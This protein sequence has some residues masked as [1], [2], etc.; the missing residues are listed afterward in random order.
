M[1][2]RL[3]LKLGN[4]LAAGVA[5][6]AALPSLAFWWRSSRGERAAEQWVD[7]GSPHELPQNEWV[8]RRF[9]YEHVNRWRQEVTEELVYVHRAGRDLTVLSPICPHARCVVQIA[10]G[11]FVC[12]CHRSAFDATGVPLDGP[13]PRPLDP[14]PWKVEQG[15]LLVDYQHFRPG[16]PESE[17]LAT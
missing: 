1:T 7:V 14:L 4:V 13:A 15:R 2:R 3:L 12:P 5:L 16:I 11:G 8:E 10:D 9:T 6:G 17:T